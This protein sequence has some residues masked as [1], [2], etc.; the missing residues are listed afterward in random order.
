M[1][2]TSTI[3]WSFGIWSK[4]ERWKSSHKQVSC[5]LTE[6]QN[7]RYF[8]TGVFSYSM[9]QQWTISQS[10]C[11]MQQ[12]VNFVQ[13]PVMTSSVVGPTRSS[14]ALP[15]AKLAP[16]KVTVWWSAIGLIHYSFLNPGETITSEK[17][18]LQI[19]ELLKTAAPAAALVNRKGP[20]LLQDNAW[21]RHTTSASKT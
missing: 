18:A 2:S 7:N 11:D 21:P 19:N 8:K 12:K 15:Q 4:L 1:N 13:Q 5:E 20:I 10:D 6:N 14:K 9:Q 17:Y 16:K 3:L